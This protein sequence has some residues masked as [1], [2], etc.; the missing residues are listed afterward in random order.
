VLS[1]YDRETAGA[2]VSVAGQSGPVRVEGL[3]CRPSVTRASRDHLH[4]AVDGR[5][6]HEDTLRS[7]VESGYGR[8]L[9]GDRHPVAVVDVSVP[10]ER[11]DVN[12]HPRKHEVAFADADAVRAA[13]ETA[14]ADALGTTESRGEVEAARAAA[15]D[16]DGVAEPVAGSVLADTTVVGVFRELYVLCERD[17]ELLVVDG[18]AAHERVTYERLQATVEDRVPTASVDPPAALALSASEAALLRD[19]AARETVERLGF[20]VTLRGDDTAR[21]STVPAPR[22]RSVAPSALRDTLDAVAAAEA[23]DPATTLDLDRPLVDLACHESL[24][25]GEID[26]STAEELIT[27][28]A[29]CDRPET[30]PHG[31]PTVLTVPETA[32]ARGFDR[33][34][35][36]FD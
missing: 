4:T 8:L 10:P 6:V 16:L 9:A 13:V 24:R 27:A 34:N 17:D 22:G 33:P 32:L 20:A 31:R 7:A 18:H 30:C 25:A 2:A 1:V 29:A 28:L 3:V 21:V 5:L 35:T 36:R 14:V 12:V 19:D 15:L 23:A 26:R 11:V